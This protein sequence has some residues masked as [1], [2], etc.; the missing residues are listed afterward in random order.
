MT[1]PRCFADFESRPDQCPECGVNLMRN[2]SG[3]MKTSAVMIAAAGEQ[4][5]YRSVQD[6]PEPLRTQLLEITA[7]SNSGTIVIADR[8]G[9]EQIGQVTGR[10]ESGRDRAAAALASRGGSKASPRFLGSSFLG[11]SLFG[12]SGTIWAGIMLILIAAGIIAAVFTIH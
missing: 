7:S 6:V 9:K 8:A 5:F 10:R 4:G 3:V 11:F 2:V 12:I 1:C